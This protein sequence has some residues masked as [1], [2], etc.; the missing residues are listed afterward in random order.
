MTS[1]LIK[2]HR[3]T[4]ELELTPYDSFRDATLERLRLDGTNDNPDLE[5]VAIACESEEHL[6]QSHS[7]YFSAV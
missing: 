2:Y 6:R 5:I 4:G 7:R 3:R 1:F